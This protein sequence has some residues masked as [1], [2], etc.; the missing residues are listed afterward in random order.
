MTIPSVSIS[1]SSPAGSDNIS[2]GDNRIREWKTQNREILEVDHEYPSSGQSATAGQHK[3]VTLQEQA[4]LG[5]GAVSATIFGS[6]TIGGKGELVY[7]DEDDNDVQI[8]TQ[9]YLH[10][11]IVQDGTQTKTNAAPTDDKDVA[12]KKYVDD[13][14]KALGAWASKSASTDYL[15]ATDGFVLAYGTNFNV[16]TDG[17][18]PPTTTRLTTGIEGMACCPVKSGD[19]YKAN[20]AGVTAVFWIPLS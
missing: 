18:N 1:E 20:G 6:Q 10:V 3:Q 8:T 4:D 15:A 9:G 13:T 14:V 5:T 16:L 7:T 17:S 19:Y 11:N 2:L 12:N